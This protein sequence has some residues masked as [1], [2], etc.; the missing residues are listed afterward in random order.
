MDSFSR[1]TQPALALENYFDHI[2]NSFYENIHKKDNGGEI[3]L[4]YTKRYGIPIQS[5]ILF[6]DSDNVCKIFTELGGVAC[7][8]TQDQNILY[9]L[10][11][12]ADRDGL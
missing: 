2:S 1:F 12:L 11:K 10:E 7:L 8:I 4:K 3:F 9:H 5:C 6:D